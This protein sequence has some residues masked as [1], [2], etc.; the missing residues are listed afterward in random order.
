MSKALFLGW[1]AILCVALA[2]LIQMVIDW[3]QSDAYG[4]PFPFWLKVL[5]VIA[6][7]LTLIAVFMSFMSGK[8]KVKRGPSPRKSK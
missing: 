7:V 1:V 4:I 3:Y 8:I 5:T 6:A 2:T